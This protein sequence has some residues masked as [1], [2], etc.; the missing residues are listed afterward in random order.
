ME[1]VGDLEIQSLE[2]TFLPMENNSTS[3]SVLMSL[4][5][6]EKPQYLV[7]AL[8]SVFAQ[9][10]PATQVVLV[11]DGPVP[12]EL[13]EVVCRYEAEHPEMK[14]VRKPENRGLGKA[15]NSGLKCCTGDLVARMDTDDIAMSDR[16]E[17]QLAVF[18]EHPEVDVCSAWLAEFSSDP[19]VTENVKCVPETHEEIY[20]YGKKRNPMNHPVVMFRRESVLNNGS[21]RHFPLFEDY[22][23]WVRML[24][25][26]CVLYNIQE[27]LLKFRANKKMYGRRGGIRYALTESRLQMLFYGM[28]YISFRRMLLNMAIRWCARLLPNKL[29]SLLY[30]YGL[31]K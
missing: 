9:S 30:K 12:P 1:A 18:L 19:D 16:F 8:D 21:Y 6:K 3:I 20:E 29:R 26:G 4:Y 17:K 10:V 11:E 31:R 5:E 25:N 15:L 28:W 22:Y 2:N 27:P 23:L 24:T 7:A 14:V 13:E